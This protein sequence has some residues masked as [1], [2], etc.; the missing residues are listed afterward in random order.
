MTSVMNYIS[1]AKRFLMTRGP[2][3]TQFMA[4]MVL[5]TKRGLENRSTHTPHQSPPFNPEAIKDTAA[6]LQGMGVDGLAARVALLLGFAT[7]LRPSNIFVTKSGGVPTNHILRR[8][9]ITVTK[10]G[11]HVK[12]HSTKSTKTPTTLP[13]IRA[14]GPACPVKAWQDYVAAVPSDQAAPILTDLLGRPYSTQRLLP[15]VRGALAALNHPEAMNF[16][17]HGSRRSGARSAA[18]GGATCTQVKRHGQWKSNAVYSYV[19][20]NHFN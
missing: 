9:D 12:V 3:T 5:T 13:V 6:V 15:V 4:P 7:F 16:T 8:A 19:P 1:G 14:A 20:K 2:T 11:L 10:S 18:S 17:F